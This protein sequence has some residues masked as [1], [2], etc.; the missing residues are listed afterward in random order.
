MSTKQIKDLTEVTSLNSG[1]VFAIDN[2]SNNTRKI[3]KSNL[4]ASLSVSASPAGSDEQI[5]FNDNGSLAANSNFVFDGTHLGIGTSNPTA[6][7]HI[8]SSGVDDTVYISN[9][10]TGSDA[11]PV[12]SMKR[13]SSS[14][15]NGDYL[16]QI[17]FYGENDIGQEVVYAKIT[18][19]IGDQ[20]DGTED[21]LIEIALKV[22]GSNLIVSRQ[23]ASA[24]KLING[25][26]LEVDGNIGA[27]LTSA[28][29]FVD[30]A[31][32]T[33]SNAQLRF[34]AGVDPSSPQAGEMWYDGT[35]LKFYDGAATIIIV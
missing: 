30:I 32:G 16:G 10:N 27:G 31:A 17:K 13:D 34:R 20:T 8:E 35:N 14:P 1:D 5:Q 28:S 2:T 25:N 19:K 12:L 29:A 11:S 15:S 6:E 24:L 7:L 4:E 23:T 33:T 22:D 18:S 21:G 9:S 26:G 3:T